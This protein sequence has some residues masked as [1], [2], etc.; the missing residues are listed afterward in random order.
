MIL[1][2]GVIMLSPK[3]MLHLSADGE[4]GLFVGCQG[5]VEFFAIFQGMLKNLVFFMDLAFNFFAHDKF[6]NAFFPSVL[7]HKSEPS[8][9]F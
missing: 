1:I 8:N 2:L 9:F 3:E 4:S 6:E 7:F 5:V